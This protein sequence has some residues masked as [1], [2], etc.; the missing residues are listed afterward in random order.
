MC[1]AGTWTG[2]ARLYVNGKAVGDEQSVTPVAGDGD[3]QIGRA[4]GTAGY[5][6][7]WQG[8]VGDV[9]VY[10]RVAVSAEVAELGVRKARLL[11]RWE[12]ETAP[13]G[14]SPEAD[15]GQPLTLGQGASIYRTDDACDPATDPECAPRTWC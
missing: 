5:R 11:G 7:R 3:F 13:Q 1:S 4:Q 2:K 6:D 14:V 15:G 12:L 8:E 10:D 9:R